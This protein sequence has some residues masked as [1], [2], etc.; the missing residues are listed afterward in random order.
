MVEAFS[1]R[2]QGN[3]KITLI[4]C[5]CTNKYFCTMS[6]QYYQDV[7]DTINNY[8]KK[9]FYFVVTCT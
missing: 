6:C 2:V 7:T 5:V 4:A 1:A 3:K 9:L 8:K